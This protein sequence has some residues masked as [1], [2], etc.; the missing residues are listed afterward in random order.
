MGHLVTAQGMEKVGHREALDTE[1]DHFQQLNDW[2]RDRGEAV[3]D[4]EMMGAI[5]HAAEQLHA[6]MNLSGTAVEALVK[7]VAGD[8]TRE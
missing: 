7:Y 6:A 3:D 4:D 8:A 1:V 5:R 2:L